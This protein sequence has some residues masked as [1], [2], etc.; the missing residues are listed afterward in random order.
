MLLQPIYE[1]ALIRVVNPGIPNRE[2]I[3]L[4]P[5]EKVDL[6]RFA[7][8]IGL[9]SPVAGMLQPI[10]GEFFWFGDRVIE[11]PAWLVVYT[12][13]GEY[14]ETQIVETQEPAHVFHMGSRLETQLRGLAHGARL[15]RSWAAQPACAIGRCQTVPGSIFLVS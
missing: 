1:I 11:P 10:P 14:R 6:G 2:R 9:Q 13:P 4:R 15:C 5:T 8:L 7:I 3:I 12:G